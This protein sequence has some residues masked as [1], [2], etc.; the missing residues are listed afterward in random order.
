MAIALRDGSVTVWDPAT[1]RTTELG[2]HPRT[3]MHL[4]WSRDGVQLASSGL[5][6]TIGVWDGRAW[7]TIERGE[8]CGSIAFSP[9]GRELASCCGPRGIQIRNLAAH[10]DRAFVTQ[11]DSCVSVRWSPD[12]A[13]LV[14]SIGD[15]SDAR[16]WDARS[17]E[18]RT[19]R[20]DGAHQVL[21]RFTDDGRAVRTID[22]FAPGHVRQFADDLPLDP[23]ALRTAIAAI[24]HDRLAW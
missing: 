15:S 4:A 3:D 17:G 20:H 18:G 23:A 13:R 10:T 21:A 8:A 14:S 7:Q 19:L 22:A 16:V 12:G 1:G 24:A 5:D 6:G 11:G 2:R 9:D